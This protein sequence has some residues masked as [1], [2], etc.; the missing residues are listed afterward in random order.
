MDMDMAAVALMVVVLAAAVVVAG[1]FFD[2]RRV[3]TLWRRRGK[4]AAVPVRNGPHPPVPSARA[5]AVA[6]VDTPTLEIPGLAEAGHHRDWLGSW[7]FETRE[8]P[9]VE[10]VRR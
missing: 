5:V 3:V 9:L 1:R 6:V 10:Q 4:A 7:L 8:Q 2:L